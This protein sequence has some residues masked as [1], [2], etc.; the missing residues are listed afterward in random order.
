MVLDILYKI[1]IIKLLLYVGSHYYHNNYFG[2]SN[3]PSYL[4]GTF[5]CSGSEK[6]LMNCPRSSYNSLLN[7]KSNEIAGVHCEGKILTSIYYS[8]TA[9]YI[10][11][12]KINFK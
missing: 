2:V 7:C 3:N 10:V 6:S 1:N 5:S 9:A 12:L 11:L 8:L 4:Y